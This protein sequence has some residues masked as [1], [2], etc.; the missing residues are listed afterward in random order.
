MTS[1]PGARPRM[2]DGIRVIDYSHF[3]AGPYLSRCL[4]AM[5]ADVIKVERPTEGDA[6]RQSPYL[7]DGYSRLLVHLGDLLCRVRYLGCGYNEILSF[8]LGGEMA[9]Q[10]LVKSYPVLAEMD[11]ARF[12]MD[13]DGLWTRSSALGMRCLEVYLR[14]RHKRRDRETRIRRTWI[15]LWTRCVVGN[16][17]FSNRESHEHHPPC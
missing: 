13:I 14:H 11:V 16:R 3:L 9:W 2:L 10:T 8:E 15:T 7:L 17:D 12:T 1:S 6:S 4:A 5:G